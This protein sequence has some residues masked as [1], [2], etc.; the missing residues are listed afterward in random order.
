MSIFKALFNII[1]ARE[2][3]NIISKS[4]LK[5]FYERFTGLNGQE[6]DKVTEEGY[7]TASAVRFIKHSISISN[8]RNLHRME[9]M[10]LTLTVTSS[11]FPTFCLEKLYMVQVRVIK[12]RN[13]ITR[14][15]CSQENTFLAALITEIWLKNTRLS[16]TMFEDEHCKII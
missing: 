1:V 7:R 16:M 12:K 6:L 2:G 11:S 3:S 4:A 10:T 5:N 8:F 14:E 15:T 13:G 9:T